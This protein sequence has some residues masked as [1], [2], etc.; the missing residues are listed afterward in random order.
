MKNKKL[1]KIL[2]TVV[3]CL[4]LVCAAIGISV[5][6]A[7]TAPEIEYKNL[8][9]EGKVQVVYYVNTANVPAGYTVKLATWMAADQSDLA[10]KEAESFTKFVGETEYTIFASEGIAPKKMRDTVYAQTVLY[11]GEGAEV[12]RGELVEYSVYTYVNNRLGKGATADQKALYHAL[13]D[14]GASAQK[15][16]GYKTTELANDMFYDYSNLS[17][18]AMQKT[19]TYLVFDGSNWSVGTSANYTY[20]VERGS[21]PHTELGVDGNSFTYAKPMV[22]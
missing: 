6:A 11:N 1:I 9:Y 15:V 5:S 12:D 10:I 13:V 3:S 18:S 2:A 4:L 21:G 16:L 14:Y 7:E 8:A 17:T 19:I 20:A 22:I